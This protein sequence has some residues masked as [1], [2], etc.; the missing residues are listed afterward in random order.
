[1]TR[2][3]KQERLD[4]ATRTVL[5]DQITVEVVR[6][7]DAA[8]VA[9]I[10]LKGPTFAA[11]LYPTGGRSYGDTDLLVAPDDL[12]AAGKVLTELGFTNTSD[13]LHSTEHAFA[14]E[15]V[16]VRDERRD[17]VDLHWGLDP[18]GDP[19]EAWRLLSRETE[20]MPLGPI[21]VMSLNTAGRALH[22]ALHAAQHGLMGPQPADSGGQTGEDLRRALAVIPEPLWAKAAALATAIGS[23]DAFG[24]GLR[25]TPAGSALATRLNLAT[26]RPAAWRFGGS[27]Q[28]PRGAARLARFHDA[29]TRRAKVGVLARGAFPS[30]AHVRHSA[31]TRLG[32][33]FVVF[34]YLEYWRI[35]ASGLAHAA[36]FNRR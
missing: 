15:F 19:R 31:R 5:V 28:V 18:G 3:N 27:G 12:S 2:D 17:I 6:A 23:V 35:A 20:A 10:L 24:F 21:T 26:D 36:R 34:G 22:V 11:L 29:P 16:R 30:R 13:G 33:R 14:R 25:M 7:L 8:S 9:S 4:A 32:Q 1:M